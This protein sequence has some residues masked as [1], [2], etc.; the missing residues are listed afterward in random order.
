LARVY[1]LVTL[2][3]VAGALCGHPFVSNWA[4]ADAYLLDAWKHYIAND[5]G[6]RGVLLIGHS[7]GA[8]RLTTLLR[9]E[10]DPNPVL[11]RRLV[12]ALLLGTN[13]QVPVGGEVGGQLANI[14]LCARGDQTGCVITY[15]SF[16]ATAPPPANSLFGRS[17]RTGWQAAC[18][19]PAQLATGTNV[20]H[21]YLPTDG[22]SL[23]IGA[24]QAPE[25]IDPALGVS[26]TTPFVT[27]PNFLEAEC[28]EDDG[29]TYLA[30]TVN[31]DPDDARVDDI[32]GD[33]TPDWG[34]HL[35]DV[36]VAMGDLV[37]IAGRQGAAHVASQCPGDCDTDGAATVDELLYGVSVLLGRSPLGRCA[38]LD[39]DQDATVS[40]NEIVAAVD[41]AL[42]GCGTP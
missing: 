3:A 36:S 40:V 14:P 38:V 9:N 16:R 42:S 28:R 41:S 31:G 13:F 29:F 39:R 20:L 35:V 33:L 1:R 2:R 8:S 17:L 5:N 24:P 32:G 23:P 11:R 12:S 22:R 30:I 34:L 18:T 10:I 27:L 26:I 37:T 6:G 7:Q 15:A 21:A 4:L 25:W 19:N